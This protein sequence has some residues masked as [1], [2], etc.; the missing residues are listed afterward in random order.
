[1]A[2]RLDQVRT[3]IAQAAADCGRAADEITLIGVSKFFPAEHARS[4]YELGLED[5]G[6]NRVQEL[7]EK[8]DQLHADGIDPKWHLIGTLQKNKVKYIIGKTHLIHSVDSTE[9]LQ[10]ISKR[11]VAQ[12]LVTQV[13]LQ[14]NVS[15]EHSKHGFG[16]ME[17]KRIIEDLSKLPGTTLRGLMTMAPITSDPEET[18]P[19]FRD[20]SN[21]AQELQALIPNE[22][23]DI[24]S[25]GMSQD[26]RQA[27][28]YGATHIR[29][30][31]AIFGP[32]V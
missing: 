5:L 32:R 25:M 22:R 3:S 31:T 26:Y 23:F 2:A 27:I 24:L 6:E 9:L 18:R 30:G 4:A 8:I 11:S 7:V 20:T 28:A 10:E 12:N 29:I 17:I 14:V 13:L 16:P 1:M 19:V 21:L 15:G